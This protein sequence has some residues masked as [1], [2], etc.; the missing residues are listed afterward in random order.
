MRIQGRARD[1]AWGGTSALPALFGY[2]PAETRVAEIWLG[3][4]PDDSRGAGPAR[5]EARAPQSSRKNPPPW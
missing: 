5:R 1:Y 4:H 3:A 2:A